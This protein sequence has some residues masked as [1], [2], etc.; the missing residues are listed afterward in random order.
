VIRIFSSYDPGEKVTLDVLRL[1]RRI[2]LVATVP[3]EPPMAQLGNLNRKDAL[4][5]RGMVF[6]LHG[7]VRML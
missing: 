2:S 1:H 6:S 3:A 4:G 5:G 7:G